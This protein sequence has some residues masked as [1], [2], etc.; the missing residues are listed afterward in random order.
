MIT[1][2]IDSAAGWL[3][4]GLVAIVSGLNGVVALMFSSYC[5]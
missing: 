4:L 5:S 3:I 1:S 2:V